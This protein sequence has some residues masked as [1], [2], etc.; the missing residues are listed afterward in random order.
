MTDE[1][2]VF[3]GRK[4]TDPFP[5]EMISGLT[6]FR[7]SNVLNPKGSD[8]LEEVRALGRICFDFLISEFNDRAN[9]GN[10]LPRHGD[11]KPSIGRTPPPGSDEQ[12]G[13]VFLGE[14][15]VDF[16]YFLCDG[17]SG[18]RFEICRFDINDIR[19]LLVLPISQSLV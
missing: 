2:Q 1:I 19:D 16:V 11:A 7:D 13:A 3:H 6:L 4:R 14:S 15:P 8:I 5:I 18:F 9:A 12:V 10:V 17:Q